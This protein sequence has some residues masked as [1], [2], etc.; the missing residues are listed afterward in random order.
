MGRRLQRY[1]RPRRGDLG[2][3]PG[4][5]RIEISPPERLQ[6]PVEISFPD[7]GRGELEAPVSRIC[8]IIA[9][10]GDEKRCGLLPGRRI[11]RSFVESF[12]E[13]APVT[14]RRTIKRRVETGGAVSTS[15]CLRSHR[16][17]TF[18]TLGDKNVVIFTYRCVARSLLIIVDNKMIHERSE[19][20]RSS[21]IRVRRSNRSVC[22]QGA[23]AEHTRCVQRDGLPDLKFLRWSV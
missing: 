17:R 8:W 12:E 14:T 21:W 22:R 9:G 6:N 4:V 11:G 3:S 10:A 1:E 5:P 7:T 2:V 20:N 13:P 18:S 19:P 16:G 23:G 15:G